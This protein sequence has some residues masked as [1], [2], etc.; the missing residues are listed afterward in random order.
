M[1]VFSQLE[2]LFAT[3]RS[4]AASASITIRSL[5][6]RDQASRNAVACQIANRSITSSVARRTRHCEAPPFL[7]YILKCLNKLYYLFCKKMFYSQDGSPLVGIV[8]VS[9]QFPYDK[10]VREVTF[11]FSDFLGKKKNYYNYY[12]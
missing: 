5:M 10:Y 1:F 11:G 2:L 3:P 7:N 12:L 9:F 6:S 4:C 8:S